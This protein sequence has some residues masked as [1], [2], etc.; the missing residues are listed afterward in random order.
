MRTD[1]GD[2]VTARFVIPAVGALSTANMPPIKGLG[3]FKGKCYHTSQWPHDGV[4]FTAKRVG[5][6]GTGATAVQAIPEIAQQAKHLTVFQ[7]TPNFCVPARNGRVDPEVTRARKADYDGIRQR[8]K[9]SF[10]GFELNFI[11]KAVLET[12]PEEREQEFDKMWDAGGFAFWLANYQDMFFS[13]EANDV[14]AD[15]L[16]RKIRSIVNDPAI[17]EKLIPKTYPYGTKRQPLDTNYFETFNKKNVRWWMP[18]PT[19]QS[20]RSRRMAF[21]RVA[22]STARHH[23][24]RHRLRRDDRPAEEPRHQGA[25][26]QGAGARV[27]GRPA[28]LSRP[29]DR[30]VSQPVHDHRPAEPSVLSNMPV[31]IEQHVEWITECIAHMR[32]N[33]L[34]TIEA[35]P[36]AQD[37]WG[38]HVA[39]VVNST[40]MP[41]TNS[42]YMGANIE[43]KP[44][45]FLPYLG[46]EGVGGY[47]RKCAEVAEKGYEGFVFASQGQGGTVHTIAAE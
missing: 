14:I 8:I 34:A 7:R 6:I 15:Y 37:A 9:D 13:K 43:G 5:V 47:R 46:P 39:E 2:A 10:F 29:G 25:R 38:A 33:K 35:S 21:A 19:V 3:S 17:A 40:L 16:K 32:R 28:D 36:Q 45:R 23:R 41:G 22:R 42:W 12:S 30:R 26:R 1:K 11:P 27:G 31:S 18:A 24:H 20:R 4:D 44:R